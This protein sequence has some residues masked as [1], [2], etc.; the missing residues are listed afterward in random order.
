M[1]GASNTKRKTPLHLGISCHSLNA[2]GQ[3][4]TDSFRRCLSSIAIIALSRRENNCWGR[5]DSNRRRRFG[6]VLDRHL[7]LIA[8]PRPHTSAIIKNQI[9]DVIIVSIVESENKLIQIG[10][11]ILSGHTMIN[12]DDCSLE[13]TPEVLD[14]HCVDIAVDEGFGM[15]YDFMSSTTGGLGIALEFIGN[16]QFG[17]DADESIE[18]RGKRFSFEVLD[19]P[20]YY[21]TASLL[22]PHDN[23]FTWSA[24]SSLPARPLAADVGVVGFNDTTELVFEPIPW[25]HCFSYLHANAPR[26]LVSDSKGSLKL[27]GT[28]SL[29][30]TTHEPDSNKP[31]LEGRP[32]T[33]KDGACSNRELISTSGALPNVPFFDPIGV[34]GSALGATNTFGPTLATKK[35][36]AFVLGGESFLEFEN[37]HALSPRHL[38]YHESHAVSRG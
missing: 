3:S 11:E 12:T 38:L 30:V 31:F 37:I 22:E 1:I 2:S 36:L 17:I 21:V 29:L 28:D 18:E 9:K 19:D 5:P 20:G 6:R 35:N 32:T 4:P 24:T 8:L 7:G 27:F 16:K 33:M 10:L 26:S 15:T 13:Q 34:F 25:P 23:L 14:A